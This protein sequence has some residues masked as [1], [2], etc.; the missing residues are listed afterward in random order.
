VSLLTDQPVEVPRARRPCA[1]CAADILGM[2]DANRAELFLLNCG[3]CGN[4]VPQ[5]H[6]RGHYRKAHER[7]GNA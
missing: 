5:R 4:R 3:R 6:S 2:P 1:V 7:F